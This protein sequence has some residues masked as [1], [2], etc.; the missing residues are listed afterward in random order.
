MDARFDTTQLC[1][2][3][4]LVQPFVNLL[5]KLPNIPREVLDPLEE[6]DPDARL[7]I[8]AVHELLAGAIHL[9]GDPDIGLKAAREITPGMY[10]AL[11][12]VARSAPNWG[13]AA[14]TV[15]RY[16]RLVNDA[17]RFSVRVEGERAFIQLDSAIALPRASADFQ[18]AAFHICT[19][20]NGPVPD[21]PDFEVWFM[22]AAPEDRREYE[23]TFEG[24]VFRF[25]A[26][27]NGFSLPSSYLELPVHGADP[28][29]HALIRKHADA[30][31]AELPRAQSLTERVRSLLADQLAAGAPT[32]GQIARRL[33]M[34][35]RTLARH[36]E[37]EGTNFKALFEDLRRRLALRYVR[38]S[39]LPFGEIAYLLG[40]SQTAAFHRA[41]RRWT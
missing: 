34:S 26:P 18:S 1:F 35:E 9:T 36:L 37:D 15:G 39:E 21:N 11:E 27:F 7:P 3:A 29:L 16:M 20:Q 33:G 28:N 17:L 13:E 31:L 22:H 14:N 24:G 25:D 40:F 4:R 32:L 19:R 2:S 6:L 38:S 41:F 5:R 8:A 23:L 10:G 12:Y 30:M